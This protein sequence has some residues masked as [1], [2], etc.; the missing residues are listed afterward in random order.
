M[1]VGRGIKVTKNKKPKVLVRVAWTTTH[2]F[3]MIYYYITTFTVTLLFATYCRNGL[4]RTSDFCSPWY[5]FLQ[6]QFEI[7]APLTDSSFYY[8]KKK[9]CV[10]KHNSSQPAGNHGTTAA[11][12]PR[13]YSTASFTKWS[14]N[15]F[16]D[17]SS[18]KIFSMD[19]PPLPCSLLWVTLGFNLANKKRAALLCWSATM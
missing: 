9:A 13:F 16:N 1:W 15:T 4:L 18:V 19:T 12:P 8:L 3:K 11:P 10:T 6:L 17:T 14:M 2:T 5:M 7:W